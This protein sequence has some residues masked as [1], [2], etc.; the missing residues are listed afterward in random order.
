MAAMPLGVCVVGGRPRIGLLVLLLA[1]ARVAGAS[2]MRP[3]LRSSRR[4][5][6]DSGAASNSSSAA[7]AAPR[8][9]PLA[10]GAAIAAHILPRA[11]I[12]VRSVSARVEEAAAAAERANTSI[13]AAVAAAERAEAGKAN[14]TRVAAANGEA[15][16]AD[17]GLL[18]GRAGSYNKCS[19]A[20]DNC[21][22]T[23]SMYCHAICQKGGWA[24]CNTQDTAPGWTERSVWYTIPGEALAGSQ[25]VNGI[26]KGCPRN[27]KDYPDVKKQMWP[28][29][30]CPS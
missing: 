2:A 1:M 26:K 28:Y 11:H 17:R 20:C 30:P 13:A 27:C 5:P 3:G 9:I 21:F 22:S 4:Q 6:V 19:I 29:G 15:L 8:I 23:H 24:Y 25:C 14:A 7:A 12:S 16:S 18:S 10:P